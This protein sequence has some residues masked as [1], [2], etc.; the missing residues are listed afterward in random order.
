MNRN[1][2]IDI[3]SGIMEMYPGRFDGLGNLAMEMWYEA[4]SDLDFTITKKAVVN[5]IKSSKFPPT[6]ADI[7]EQY[8]KYKDK[9]KEYINALENIFKEIKENY[10]NGDKDSKAE[11]YYFCWLCDVDPS[12]RYRSAN[13]LKDKVIAYVKSCEDG[14]CILDMTLFECIERMVK[15]L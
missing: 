3:M 10:P 13:E 15:Q 4:L 1:E 2:F 9:Q 8:S 5:H 12:I 7:R 6:V 14:F 11:S